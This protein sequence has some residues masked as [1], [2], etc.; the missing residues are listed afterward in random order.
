MAGSLPIGGSTGACH[1]STAAIQVAA[2]W[3]ASTPQA[4]RPKPIVPHLQ[5]TFGLSA[6]EAVMAIREARS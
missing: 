1:E 2:E 4:E 3:L 6:V 5:K